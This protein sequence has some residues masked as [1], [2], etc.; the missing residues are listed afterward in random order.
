MIFLRSFIS[1]LKIDLNSYELS[2][3]RHKRLTCC[4]SVLK[5]IN[6]AMLIKFKRLVNVKLNY[7]NRKGSLN[8]FELHPLHL[9]LFLGS[10]FSS[11]TAITGSMPVSD[12][13]SK[14]LFDMGKDERNEEREGLL[15]GSQSSQSQCEKGEDAL[16]PAWSRNRIVGVAASFILLLICGTFARSLA[17]SRGPY[18]HPNL[19]FHGEEVRSNGT[20]D[21]K[22]T[23]LII[24]IDGLRYV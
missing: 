2:L 15:S 11:A 17:C 23:V 9:L 20:H 8:S 12:V 4:M 1:I 24:S 13:A 18:V 22:R 16:H 19:H 10:P 21:F 3:N 14:W 7:L 6:K 5:N